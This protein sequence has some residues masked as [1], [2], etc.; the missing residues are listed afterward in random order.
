[1]VNSLNKSIFKSTSIVASVSVLARINRFRNE[2][3]R[4]M[5]LK[6]NKYLEVNDSKLAEYNLSLIH[7]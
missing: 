2:Y 3:S 5:G 6:G 1:M 7:I 4:R